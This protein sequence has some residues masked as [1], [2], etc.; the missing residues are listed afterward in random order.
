MSKQDENRIANTRHVYCRNGC[1]TKIYFNEKL[2]S[3]NGKIIP[4]EDPQGIPHECPLRNQ[5]LWMP[6]PQDKDPTLV[7]LQNIDRNTI[8]NRSYYNCDSDIAPL[9]EIIDHIN[10]Q[11][12]I[13]FTEFSYVKNQLEIVVRSM[14]E[15][16]A[17][18][19]AKRKEMRENP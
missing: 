3:K 13:I 14:E 10:K 18:S 17:N 5:N 6:N 2:L 19:S 7:N 1:G 4:L 11:N 12:K 8:E 15:L 16:I 9:L